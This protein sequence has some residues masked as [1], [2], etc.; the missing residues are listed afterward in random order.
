MPELAE[1]QG[2]LL[3]AKQKRGLSRKLA[4]AFAAAAVLS[5]LG[6]ALYLF[7]RPGEEADVETVLALFYLD[8]ALLLLL[9]L[10]VGRRLAAIWMERRRKRAGAGLHIK[11]AL[12]FGLISTAPAVLMAIFATLFVNHG[13]QVWFGE[14]VSATLD[15]SVKVAQSYLTEHRENFKSEILEVATDLDMNAEAFRRFPWQVN[16]RLTEQMTR[17][18]LTEL[19]LVDS[20]GTVLNKSALSLAGNVMTIPADAFIN[21]GIGRITL[22]APAAEERD[23]VRGL[24]KLTNWLNTYLVVERFVDPVVLDHLDTI[25]AAVQE[26]KTLEEER[27]GVQISFALIFLVSALLLLLAAIWIGLTVATRMADPISHVISAAEQVRAGNLN[28]YVDPPEAD[29]EISS[30]SRAFNRMTTQIRVQQEGLIDANQQLDERRRFTETV[31]GGVSAGV[32]G[33]DAEGRINLPNRS[34]STLLETD[35]DAAAGQALSSAVPEM[36]KLFEAARMRPARTHRDELR[37]IRGAR[38]HILLVRIVAE[39]LNGKVIGYVVTFDD[40]TE[41]QSAQRKAAWSDVARRIAHEIKNPLTPIQLSAER[42]G[43]K[44]LEQITEGRDAFER[45]IQTIVRQ[46]GDIGRMVDEFSSFARMPQPKI[47]SEDLGQLLREAVFLERER[48]SELTFDLQIPNA[49]LVIACDRRQVSRVF[50]NVIKNAVES[51]ETRI[52]KEP[53]EAGRIWVS[54]IDGRNEGTL[55]EIVVEDNGVGLPEGDRARLTEPYVTTREKGTGLG[56]AIVKKIMEEHGGGLVLE[57]RAG[58]GARIRLSFGEVDDALLAGGVNVD[59]DP[60]KVATSPLSG[61]F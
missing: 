4:Y 18:G 2:G 21:A 5:C 23:R 48:A 38:H 17:F 40:I 39:R 13:L 20:N 11:L 54:M 30:L 50:T 16:P 45:Y 42:L 58:G 22:M 59:M 55:L 6:T 37:L 3:A 44:Y 15:R 47:Q 34:A 9:G 25:G 7:G 33:L 28:V 24:Y 36:S 53:A 32:I 27:G 57:D 49:G 56:L 41:L 60:M 46:V 19:A 35:L 12:L 14:R 1:R 29:D 61:R 52:Q 43:S 51:V 26:Y 31:L 8:G 10:V